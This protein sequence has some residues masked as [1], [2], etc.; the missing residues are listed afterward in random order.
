MKRII[1]A[2]NCL[3]IVCL[4]SACNKNESQLL[5]KSYMGVITEVGDDFIVI[6]C[7]TTNDTEKFLL[8]EKTLE[9]SFDLIVGHKVVI[10][11][12][13]YTNDEKPYSAIMISIDSA[14]MDI[15]GDGVLEDCSLTPGP[16]SGLYTIVITAYVDGIIKYK[17]TFNLAWGEVSFSE[18]DGIAQFVRGEEYHRLYVEDNRIVIENLDPKYEGYWGD[19]DWNYD[20]R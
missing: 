15:D 1:A 16:T 10:E 9:I 3:L 7:N 19:S 6:D 13:F 18:K 11:S 4:L 17:N 5:H 2:L 20:R 12:E 14:K 8:N